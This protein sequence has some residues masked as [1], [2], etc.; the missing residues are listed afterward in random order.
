MPDERHAGEGFFSGL[1]EERGHPIPISTWLDRLA[2]RASVVVAYGDCGVWGGPHAL[3]PNPVHATGAAM[4]LGVEYRS[5]QGLPVVN[6]PGCCAPAVLLD[7][8]VA[9][10][11]HIYDGGPA[12]VL[13]DTNRPAF[14]Y[15]DTWKGALDR[16]STR[17][18]SS[19]ERLSRMPSSA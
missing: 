19:H 7:T 3:H 12:L 10:L 17:L 1:G 9:L 4:H 2:P 15:P 14:A 6:L 13:D 16:K 5:V 11:R 8:L 18:N